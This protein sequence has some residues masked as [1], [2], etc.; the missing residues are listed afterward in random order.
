MSYKTY[1]INQHFQMVQTRNIKNTLS[2]EINLLERYKD[3]QNQYIKLKTKFTFSVILTIN[4]C[5]NCKI[6]RESSQRGR[7]PKK[8]KK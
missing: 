5:L 1:Q 3:G 4:V 6:S 2:Y 8:K 7:R